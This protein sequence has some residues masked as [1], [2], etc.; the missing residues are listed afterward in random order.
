MLFPARMRPNALDEERIVM[1]IIEKWFNEPGYAPVVYTGTETIAGRAFEA[2]L[3]FVRVG[4]TGG[5]PDGP[6]DHPVVDIDVLA[7]TRNEAKDIALTIMSLLETK[8]YP[9][10]ELNVLMAPQKVEWIEGSPIRRFYA[11]YHL[12]LRRPSA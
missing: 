9:I 7:M 10:D 5:A 1:D 11:S 6:D 8:P 4:R 2:S 12:T 3:P